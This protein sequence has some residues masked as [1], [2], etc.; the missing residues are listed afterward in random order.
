MRLIDLLTA[1]TAGICLAGVGVAGVQIGIGVVNHRADRRSKERPGGRAAPI[2]TKLLDWLT[3]FVLGP[4]R[5]DHEPMYSTFVAGIFL[6]AMFWVLTGPLPRSVIFPFAAQTQITLG[7]CMWVGSGTCLYGITMGGPF[8]FWRT[9]VRIKRALRGQPKQ[10]TL[11]VRRAYRVGSSGVPALIV[12]LSY[13]TAILVRDTPIGWTAPNV[14]LLSFI[15]LGL[16]FQWLRFLMEN[17]R[18]NKTL[19]I[20]IEQ[21]TARR[22]LAQELNFTTVDADPMEIKPKRRKW[23][24]P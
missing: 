17:R 7:T 19:P 12:S 22:V 24:L 16:W 2:S 15:C 18:I 20:L 1:M 21:E 6:V 9:M 3:H 13:Y 5:L 11:D 14:I 4:K 10:P 23:W 8:D